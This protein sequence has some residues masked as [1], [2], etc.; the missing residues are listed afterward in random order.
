MPFNG[1]GVASIPNSF[2]PATTILSSA[3][4]ANF[5]DIASMLSSVLVRDGQAAMS[6]ALRLA[7]GS[8]ALPGLS[9]ANDTNTGLRRSGADVLELV[10][11]GADRVQIDA[12]GKLWALGAFDAAGA[13]HFQAAVTMA[14]TLGVTGVLSALA[15]IELGH[16][17][18]TT[19]SRQSAGNV[20]VEGNLIYR[21]GGTDIPIADGGT[22]ASTAADAFAAL[23]Q[24]A[25]DTAT[26][27]VEI[28]DAAEMAAASDT[29]KA[30]TP[31]RQHLHPHMPKALGRGAAAGGIVGNALNVASIARDNAGDYTVTLANAMPDTNYLVIACLSRA[32]TFAGGHRSLGVGIV[33][34]TVFNV[35]IF[36]DAGTDSDED[37][38]FA[39]YHF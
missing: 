15:G 6:G 14:L 30:V 4:N 3:M 2:T 26:G 11:G 10:T 31:G 9:F 18:D 38:S 17:S 22:G 33:S 16:A 23:K 8:E 35:N 32:A 5:V 34:T 37:F 27:V 36:N 20:A 7:D 19:L 28:A 24:A 1:S 39:V 29:L 13:A 25:S 12:A 21:A